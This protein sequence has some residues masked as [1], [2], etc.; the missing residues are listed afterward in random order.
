MLWD[1]KGYALR[2]VFYAMINWIERA[3]WYVIWYA[4]QWYL[5]KKKMPPH[6]E[7]FPTFWSQIFKKI[8]PQLICNVNISFLK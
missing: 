8:I 2:F 5:S 1:V 4:K 6:K 3:L 7:E